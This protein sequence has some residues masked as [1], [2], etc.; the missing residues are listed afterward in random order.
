MPDIEARFLSPMDTLI[1]DGSEYPIWEIDK[2]A[3]VKS[4]SG[5]QDR[6]AVFLEWCTD[7][8]TLFRPYEFVTVK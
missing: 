7:K 4:D 3:I 2:S 1:I 5:F 8:A 6:I